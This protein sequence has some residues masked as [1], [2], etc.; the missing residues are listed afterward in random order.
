METRTGPGWA[1][2]RLIHEAVPA[3]DLDA[4]DLSV[5]FLGRRLRAPLLIAGMTGGHDTA[6]VV[7]A[8]LARA[9][10][11]HGLAMGVGS[12]RAAVRHPELAWTYA[13]VREQAPTALLIGNVG[14]A[15]LIPQGDVPPLAAGQVQALLATL[16]ADALAI[17]LNYLQ[18]TV[19]PEGDRQA[20][21]TLTAIRAL[22]TSV[23]VPLIAKETG[24][25]MS[26]RSA[27]LL[28]GAGMRALDVGGVGG[29]SFAAVEGLRAEQQGH[30]LGARLG[31]TFREWG[32]PTAVSIAA[33][34]PT[35]LPI[36]A[37]GGI[38]TGLDAA[39]AIA[40]G[41]RL[42]GVARPLLQASLE[43][44]DAA[45]NAWIEGFLA[46]LRAA[47]FLTGSRRVGDLP[48]RPRVL[49]GETREWLTQLGYLA[50]AQP[51]PDATA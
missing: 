42:V 30:R 9:A 3:V 39:K 36:I 34:R 20:E 28:A 46:E 41:A 51:I 19:Q 50:A 17:H 23:D 26:R 13:V 37:T 32:I 40:L 4:V 35:G 43:G 1:D 33:A 7:N 27:G 48:A 15:Q 29:T 24:A 31:G 5:E 22:A 38:R 14:A 12:Q 2:V 18:E 45:V 6:G 21:G 8:C 25:G 47:V 16:R 49:L 11:R 10:E 44:G